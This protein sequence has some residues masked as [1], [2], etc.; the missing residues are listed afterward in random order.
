MNFFY[1]VA[2]GTTVF[3]PTYHTTKSET[4]KRKTKHGQQE[5]HIVRTHLFG[6]TGSTT[7]QNNKSH[8]CCYGAKQLSMI[9]CLFVRSNQ[10]HG[11]KENNTDIFLFRVL[12][13]YCGNRSC[14]IC[15]I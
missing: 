1:G 11:I 9:C 8:L 5:I 3:D 14:N 4:K 12:Q 2:T 7:K 10:P 6:T 15:W 13:Q